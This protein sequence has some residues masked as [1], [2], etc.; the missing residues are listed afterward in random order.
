MIIL[1]YQKLIINAKP[2]ILILVLFINFLLLNP[3]S[4]NCQVSITQKLMKI[5]L[6][7]PINNDTFVW[8]YLP[9][10]F[11]P[12]N[13]DSITIA[14]ITYS[15]ACEVVLNYN[16]V[17]FLDSNDCYKKFKKMYSKINHKF[18]PYFWIQDS[19]SAKIYRKICKKKPKLNL[20]STDYEW[21][22]GGYV[23]DKNGKIF[24]PDDPNF[25]AGLRLCAKWIKKE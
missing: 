20:R 25:K 12:Q 3:A 17:Y 9:R 6:F 2:S 18:V 14:K 7:Y 16:P 23:I 5:D 8:R 15:K 11:Y 10:G 13:I 1:D 24:K 22:D 4:S 19:S 21:L